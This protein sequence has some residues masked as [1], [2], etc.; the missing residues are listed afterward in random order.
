[1]STTADAGWCPD[2]FRKV[3]GN[4]SPNILRAKDG[5]G[6]CLEGNGGRD[7]FHVADP[8]VGSQIDPWGGPG[9][10]D[11][12]WTVIRDWRPGEIIYVD[13]DRVVRSD[14]VLV[15]DFVFWH[16]SAT[17]QYS[18]FRM[19]GGDDYDL[20]DIRAAVRPAP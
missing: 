6:N 9:G 15:G 20:S 1:M 11:G 2:G 5:R 16:S 14:T 3:T 4:N 8:S 19:R 12:Y 18:Y 13:A 10:D 7:T 17:A